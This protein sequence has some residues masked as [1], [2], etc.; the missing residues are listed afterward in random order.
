MVS[1][2]PNHLVFCQGINIFVLKS[3]MFLT[4]SLNINQRYQSLAFINIIHT[5]WLE[6]ENK[7]NVDKEKINYI[8]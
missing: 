5:V 6:K 3:H 2:F 7:N 4:F 1:V 8:S